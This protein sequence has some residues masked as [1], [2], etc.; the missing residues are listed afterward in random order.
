MIQGNN[1][2]VGKLI[3]ILTIFTVLISCTPI[4]S[5]PTYFVPIGVITI[6]LCFVLMHIP[7][8]YNNRRIVIVIALYA[9]ITALYRFMGISDKSWGN[10]MH[11]Y[12]FLLIIILL[13]LIEGNVIEKRGRWL[14]FIISFIIAFNVADNII[15]SN[16][17]PQINS[18]RESVDTDALAKLNA[19]SSTFFT[20]SVF[21]AGVCFFVFL[22]TKNRWLRLLFLL[23]TILTAVFIYGYCNKGS[24]VIYLTLLL[25]LI[26]VSGKTKR[27]RSLIGLI[28]F[29]SLIFIV[30]IYF[31]K[32]ELT[33]LLYSII[34]NERL[35]TR[36]VTLINPESQFAEVSVVQ[37]RTNLYVLSIETWLKNPFNF[38]FGVGDFRVS[39]NATATGVGQHAD[40]LDT[41]ARYGLVGALLL[42]FVLYRTL[43]HIDGLF[44]KKFRNHIISF[45]IVFV[46]TGC[47][48]A[49]LVP[50]VASVFFVF[51]PLSSFFVNNNRNSYSN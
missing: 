50:E 51:L 42:F 15:L 44:D 28:L 12:S 4:L 27:G 37:G 26:Y 36:L 9:L 22:N 33:N 45:Y 38:L 18:Y 30:T 32:E 46:L 31:F 40:L 13:L 23:F 8:I 24:S 5:K 48:K 41:L 7:V 35:S 17:Y 14:F 20:M 21:Y 34:P 29:L 19:G 49:M 25:L 47:S 11:E 39:E 43:K 10:S 1:T 2:L 16:L 6:L 3:G